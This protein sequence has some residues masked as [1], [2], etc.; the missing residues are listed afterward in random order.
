M[1]SR[2]CIVCTTWLLAT[3]VLSGC[4]ASQPQPSQT[5]RVTVSI[6]PQQYFVQRIGGEYVE[7]NVM[8]LPG[9]NPVTYEP[10][11][12]QLA[13]LSAADL[14]FS[15]GVP[16][17]DAWL[18]RIAAANPSMEIIDTARGIQ[19]VPV[20][21]HYKVALNGKPS[22]DAEGRDPHI[23]LSPR[24][25]KI[26]VQT[27]YEALVALDPSHQDT[28]QANRDRFLADIDRL[29]LD[30]EDTLQAIS[31]R[32]FWVFHPSWGYFGDDF[33]LEMIPIEVE[34][35]E[36]SAAELAD[37]VRTARAEGIRVVLAQPEFS[38]RDA[39]TI[40]QEIGG[41]VL[42]VS[43]LSLDWLDN[44]RSVAATFAEVLSE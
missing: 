38:T 36:P 8:V 18:A 5:L 1:R 20:D 17:E 9:A 2:W 37:W 13:A 42:L 23:W 4:G 14:Y 6:V 24:L 10:K 7:V 41:K 25:V 33:G 28:Y 30:I 12:A 29:I 35:Q 39:E 16:F 27:I 40:A 43:P 11:P 3:A 22:T 26:Q 34:G 31:N 21:A 15:I 32:K 19:R 44:L